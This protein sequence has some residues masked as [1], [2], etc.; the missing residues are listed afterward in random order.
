MKRRLP[1]LLSLSLLAF[2]AFSAI[3]G[4]IM[5]G[6][7]VPIAG[8]RVSIAAY[9]S[10]EAKKARLLSESPQQVP[11]A[12]AQTDAR[13][14]FS[15]EPPKQPVVTLQVTAAGHVPV[16][17]RVERDE[18][19]GALVLPKGEMRTGS[20]A[21]GNG[22]PVAGATVVLSYGDAEVV[23]KTD[24]QGR[25]PAVEPK[26]IRKITVAHP[27]WAI[28]EKRVEWRQTLTDRE[29][30]RTLATGVK[31]SGTVVGPDGKTPV[32]GADV[33]LDGWPLAKSGEDGTFT[34]ANAPSRWTTLAARK[35]ALLGQVAFS[36]DAAQ[37]LRLMRGATISGRVLDSS[38]KVPV[39]GAIVGA[40]AMR[41]IEEWTAE[42]DAKGTYS[43]V[44]PASAYMITTS[45]PAYEA[46]DAENTVAAGQAVVRDFTLAQ[47]ARVSGVVL[48]EERR[49]VPAA[50]I[51]DHQVGDPFRGGGFRMRMAPGTAA[52]SGPDGRFTK[53]LGVDQALTLRATKR[54]FPNA[55]S[56]QLKLAAGER[57]SGVV[58]TIPTGIAVTGKVTDA[59]GESLSGVAVTATEAEPGR[60]MFS[61]V[62][63]MGDGGA[64]DDVVR[65]ATDGTFTMRLKEGTYDFMF[66]REGF[67][68]KT[69]R[70]QGVSPASASLETSLE[71]AS[72]I[73]GRLVR[74]GKGVENAIL[75]V[76]SPGMEAS[77][78]TG[79]DGSFTLSGLAAGPVMVMMRK[80]EEFISE[81]RTLTAPGRDVVIQLPGGG[82]ITGRVVDK[83]TNKPLTQ[84]Q[85]GISMSRGGGGFVTMA[86]PQ[87][88]DFTSD[89]GSFTLENVPAG[90]MTVVANAPGYASGNMNVT[91][92]EGK[93]LSDVELA[94]D[95]GV[96]LT[97][98]V[99]SP[100]GSPLSDVRVSV[101]P[102]T[103]GAFAMRGVEPASTTDANGEYTLESLQAGE[104]KVSFS[105]PKYVST[106]KDVTL[107][108]REAR[109]D[110]QLAAGLRVTGTVVTESGA[111][112]GDAYVDIS[113]AGPP[114]RARTNAS[115]AFEVEGLTPG[116]YRFTARKTGLGEGVLE[117][118]EIGGNTPVRI[119]IS[120][121]SM[122]TGRVTGL[123]PQDY[124][125]TTVEA[126]AGR[127]NASAS[128]DSSGTFRIDGAPSGTVTVSATVASRDFS[129]RR[130]SPPQT[131]E[132]PPGGSQSVDIAFS[133]DISIRGRVTRNGSP[134][135][136]GTVMFVPRPGSQAQSFASAPTDENGVY[137]ISGVQ[138]GEY[139][140]Q[141]VDMQ[142]FSPYATQY[143]VRST[144][145][146]DIDYR[147]G[148]LNGRVVD[149]ATGAP[150][151]GA[152]VELRSKNQTEMFRMSRAAT[153]DNAGTFIL[154][155]VPAG[156]YVLSASGEGFGTDMNDLSV[157]EAGR[158][159]LE[160]RLTKNDGV[161][162]RVVDARNNQPLSASVHVYDMQGQLVPGSPTTFFGSQD[163]SA[164]KLRLPA[165]TFTASVGANLYAPQNI[166]IQSPGTELVRLTPGGVLNVRS[167]HSERY[168]IRLIDANG[169]PYMR[170]INPLPW[171]DF[172]PGTTTFA[173][174]APGDYTIL[175][176]G[177]NDAVLD[178]VKV[179]VQE[180]GT[181][182]AEL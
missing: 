60:G 153:T 179:T 10:P 14:A 138:E 107:K 173:N 75:N 154:E 18:E 39:A 147:T 68:P 174:V 97:G 56:E 25:Y 100:N 43:M 114:E 78:T 131:V 61:R 41:R 5:T 73:T 166:R 103:G 1:V 6:E 82:R 101:E 52:I 2:P 77:A 149:A 53:R 76:F 155:S 63:I 84:F 45:H 81:R 139:N 19:V 62:M 180:G 160:I 142:R 48:D 168:R 29:L 169:L 170:S 141:V 145:T 55:V 30:N 125:N 98:R 91:V 113:T 3:T 130:T 110:V 108:G 83:A 59:N 24:E 172:P 93:T 115:G 66:R 161:T 175:L 94:L 34:I 79:P 50:A 89:D 126:R 178:S 96:R 165:G 13:G 92:E 151:S 64:D 99:T 132:V 112:V 70:A 104:E 129:T 137:N 36:K 176:L 121:G 128:V 47:L 46:G 157:G 118:V 136:N 54:G 177:A 134:L 146:F 27:G 32:A 7:G 57:K 31:V 117:D 127:R 17:R 22:K 181:T 124:A 51:T 148:T 158:D 28:D 69:M 71:P 167:R 9:E 80:E 58:L 85:A 16:S 38:T 143:T 35:D 23:V 95:A 164:I 119:V 87:L 26:R 12:F 20:V 105:H 102:S 152:N 122:I 4:T 140:V 44:I 123:T 150:V 11:L 171:R 15:L 135:A 106:T 42:T 37:T 109:L 88:R 90:A 111:P 86:P 21:A 182:D 120:A 163:P 144:A 162:L 49:P 67:A 74:N 65:T 156:N 8:A 133:S 33:W 72:E 40:G 116:R 159:G